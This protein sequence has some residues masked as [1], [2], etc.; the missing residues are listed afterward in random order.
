MFTATDVSN[1]IKLYLFRHQG[2][3]TNKSY[4]LTTDVY[5]FICKTNVN[6]RVPILSFHESSQAFSP[7]PSVERGN[8][9]EKTSERRNFT[10]MHTVTVIGYDLRAKMRNCAAANQRRYTDL[11]QAA[12]SVWNFWV[13]TPEFLAEKKFYFLE[14]FLEGGRNETLGTRLAMR[15]EWTNFDE[16]KFSL[17]Q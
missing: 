17:T 4:F 11:S 16:L 1:L 10:E 12:S 7:L 15:E 13:E 2:K 6:L 9:V 14:Y 8:E 5:L 3:K